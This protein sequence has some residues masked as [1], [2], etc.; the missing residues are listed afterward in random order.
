MLKLV[1]VNAVVGRE[2][3]DVGLVTPEYPTLLY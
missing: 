3:E 1:I 2:T